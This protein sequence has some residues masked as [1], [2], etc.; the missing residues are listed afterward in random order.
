MRTIINTAMALT[1]AAMPALA[2]TSEWQHFDTDNSSLPSNALTAVGVNSLGIWAGTEQGLTCI[3]CDMFPESGAQS[4]MMPQSHIHDIHTSADGAVWVATDEGLA[5]FADREWTVWNTQNSD[6]PTDL[7]RAVTSDADGNI[8]VGTW[9]SGLVRFSDGNW[10]AFTTA[11]SDMPSNGVYDVAV[12]DLGRV[13]AGTY[14]GGAAMLENGHWTVFDPANSALPHASVLSVGHSD[15]G[16]V[17]LGTYQGLARLT[18]DGEV[19]W[20]V[21]T[22]MY[23]GHAVSAFRDMANGTDGQLWFATDAGLLWMKDGMF[24]FLD[25]QNSGLVSNNLS[26]VAA[27][28]KGNVHV[29]H[30]QKGLDVYNPDGVALPVK[31]LPLRE[32]MTLE[33]FPNP[34]TDIVNVRIPVKDEEHYSLV[35]TDLSG[36]TIINTQFRGVAAQ[37]LDVSNLPSGTYLLTLRSVNGIASAPFVKG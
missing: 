36:R 2:Q 29:A 11:N 14:A 21:F 9:G 13:W 37:T 23:F 28:E 18:M 4:A 32:A 26:A 15:D 20:Q 33:I 7:L 16:A 34:T 12:D 27:D 30:T 19:Q 22:S 1:V 17:W 24:S 35:V 31:P 10:E 25:T 3:G 8:W 5:R 6:I